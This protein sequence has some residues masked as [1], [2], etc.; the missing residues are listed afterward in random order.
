MPRNKCRRHVESDPEITFFKPRAIPM[1]DLEEI[2]LELDE[3][4]AIRLRNYEGLYQEQAAE[5]MQI[6]SRK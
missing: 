1:K 3:F 6:S 5:K 4:E 2:C